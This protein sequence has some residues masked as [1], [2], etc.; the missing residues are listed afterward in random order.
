MST[1]VVDLSNVNGPVDWAAIRRAGISA[2][3]LKATE[4]VTFDDGLYESHR[5]DAAREGIR[6]GA[7]HFARPDRNPAAD[8]ADH[9]A[10]VVD[11]VDRRD[12]RPALDLETPAA[13]VDLEVWARAWNRRVRELLGVGP[14]FYSFPAFITALRLTR[15]IGYGLWLAAFGRDDGDEHP[16]TVPA[17]W[18]RAVLHQFTSR[19]RLAG[20]PGLVDL[21]NA[22]TLRPLLAHP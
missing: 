16:F 10:A 20:V 7:Y 4:G 5:R 6:T 3:Y 2:A 8:E 12:L 15:A 17:P 21:S 22:P 19:A 14:L 18:R 1:L 13:G 11:H 9:F